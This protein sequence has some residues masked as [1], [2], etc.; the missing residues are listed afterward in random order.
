MSGSE[1][2][3]QREEMLRKFQRFQHLAELYHVYHFIHRYTVRTFVDP[4]LAQA[5]HFNL[6]GALKVTRRLFDRLSDSK[7]L[8]HGNSTHYVV[9]FLF[10]YT[11]AHVHY[12]VSIYLNYTDSPLR[13]CPFFNQLSHSNFS[14]PL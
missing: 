10:G 14:R 4:K 8:S 6:G 12:I 5:N 2:E 1:N 7:L 3:E 11:Q 13:F 9:T